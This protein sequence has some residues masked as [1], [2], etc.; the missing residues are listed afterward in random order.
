MDKTDKSAP[1]A[2]EGKFAYESVQDVETLVGYL[3]ALTDG[4]EKGKMRFSRKDLDLVLSPRGLIG[5]A[6]EAKGKE[7]R[8][9]LALKFAWRESVPEAQREDDAM[10]ITPGGGE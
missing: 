5:F 4:F 9:K 6:V 7:G 8:M 10:V 3:R 2:T 1:P